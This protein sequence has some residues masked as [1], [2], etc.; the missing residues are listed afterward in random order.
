MDYPTVEYRPSRFL[1]VLGPALIAILLIQIFRMSP[2]AIH[3]DISYIVYPTLV[4]IISALITLI[5]VLYLKTAFNV[6]ELGPCDIRIKKP[7]GEQVVRYESLKELR[8]YSSIRTLICRD[9]SNKV[10]FFTSADGFPGI[11]N[12]YNDLSMRIHGSKDQA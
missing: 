5:I 3:P 9:V 2:S 7:W 11:W 10:V 6:Y 1:H 4:I 8:Y 12:L